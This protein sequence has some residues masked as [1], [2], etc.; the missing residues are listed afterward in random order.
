[1]IIFAVI[2]FIILAG[3]IGVIAFLVPLKTYFKA[4]FSNVHI[5]MKV[6]AGMKMR[7][8]DF[9][10]IVSVFITAKKSGL[11]ISLNELE[12]HYLAKGNIYKLV[13][14]LILAKNLNV[15]ITKDTAKGIDLAKRDLIDII[16]TSITPKIVKTN[17]IS[18]ISQDCMEIKASAVIT[19]KSIIAKEFDGVNI[20]TIASRAGEAIVSFIGKSNNYHQVLENPIEMSNYIMSKNIGDNS[21]YEVVS[22]DIDS[23][24]LGQ[25]IAESMRINE[26]E[27]NAKINKAKAEEKKILAQIREQEMK[28]KTQEMKAILLASESEV[29]KAMAKAFKDG[30]MGVLDYYKLQNIM[31]DTN[32]RNSLSGKDN[33]SDDDDDFDPFS[34]FGSGNP[35][36]GSGSSSRGGVQVI[37][38]K[39]ANRMR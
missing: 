7:K 31:A 39:M 15:S 33:D 10:E 4:L 3:I 38:D 22:V 2:L 1:M 34:R 19:L 30:Q 21:C 9:D 35:F 23:I 27:T 13:N 8:I 28:A 37:P 36:R 24:T 16:K 18:A 20:D 14:G 17:T 6:L 25:N 32:L 5:P 12:A 26:A 29:H 11:D